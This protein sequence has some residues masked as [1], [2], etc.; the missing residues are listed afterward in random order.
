LKAAPAARLRACLEQTGH[1]GDAIAEALHG[2]GLAALHLVNPQRT[3]AFGMQKLRRNKSAVFLSSAMPITRR[4]VREASFQC[5]T[6]F[7][8]SIGFKVSGLRFKACRTKKSVPRLLPVA[9]TARGAEP[10]DRSCVNVNSPLFA[11]RNW[12]LD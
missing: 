9:S 2:S 10:V 12:R 8:Y 11:E 3:K 4:R 1:Y 6:R 5:A 7:S